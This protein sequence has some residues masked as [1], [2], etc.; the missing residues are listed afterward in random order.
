MDKKIVE[1]VEKEHTKEDVKYHIRFV[2]NSALK[3]AEI[4]KAD[5]EIVELACWLHDIARAKGLEAGQDNNHHI[6]GAKKTEDI[7]KKL[8]YPK[9]KIDKVINCILAHRGSKE[10]YTPKTIEEKIV[11]N[12]DAMAHFDSFLNLFLEFVN[13]NNFEEG[14]E[15]IKAKLERDWNKKLTLPEARELV[16]YKYD[17]IKLLLNEL[18]QKT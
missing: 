18:N 3:L 17:A 4:Y 6:E 1:I 8:K 16:K 14:V 13:P 15:L 12:A 5:K 10:D 11:A 9:E 7:L 2:V